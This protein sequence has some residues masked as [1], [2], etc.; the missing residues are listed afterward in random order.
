MLTEKTIYSLVS[1]YDFN[2]KTGIGLLFFVE[3]MNKDKGEASMWVTF[4]NMKNRTVLRTKR[5]VGAAGGAGFD[6]YW[7]K[8]FYNVMRITGEGLPE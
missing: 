2:H 3:G 4:V 6:D 7:A 1:N 8:S 5:I